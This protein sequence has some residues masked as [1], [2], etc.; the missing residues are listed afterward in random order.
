MYQH[1]FPNTRKEA[2]NMI[3]RLLQKYAKNVKHL[4]LKGPCHEV[5]IFLNVFFLISNFCICADGF[6]LNFLFASLK[7]LTYFE[8]A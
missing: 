2:C 3:P 5:D 8:N 4:I 7:L 1:F 6:Q